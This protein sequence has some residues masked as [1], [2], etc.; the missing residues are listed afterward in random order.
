VA[1]QHIP[2]CCTLKI[3][4][5]EH[6]HSPGA[7]RPGRSLRKDAN[8]IKPVLTAIE[9]KTWVMVLNLRL[10]GGLSIGNIG[11]V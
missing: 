11:R 2:D 6:H 3:G 1:L 9:S 4:V 10:V 8:Q 5:L 7:K